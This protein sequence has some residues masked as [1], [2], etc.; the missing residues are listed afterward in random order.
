MTTIEEY[1][2]LVTQQRELIDLLLKE[3]KLRVGHPVTIPG[4]PCP[5]VKFG[6]DKWWIPPVSS[7]GVMP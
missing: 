2:T 1:Q 7:G 4:S 3:V 5:H 6:D